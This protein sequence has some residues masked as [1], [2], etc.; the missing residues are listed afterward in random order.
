M[1]LRLNAVPVSASFSWLRIKHDI[2][3]MFGAGLL[4]DAHFETPAGFYDNITRALQVG[5]ASH[6]DQTPAFGCPSRIRRRN[7]SER[8]NSK[9]QSDA[10]ISIAAHWDHLVESRD[11][12]M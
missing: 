7:G 3:E 12:R 6:S 9:Q 5:M 1:I 8:T 10:Q 2:G 11:W 4:T